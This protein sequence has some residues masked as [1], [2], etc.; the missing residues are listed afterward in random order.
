LFSPLSPA[1]SP[2]GE[3]ELNSLK[4]NEFGSPPPSGEGWVGEFGDFDTP[5]PYLDG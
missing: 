3:R 4:I 1:L 2:V 5:P